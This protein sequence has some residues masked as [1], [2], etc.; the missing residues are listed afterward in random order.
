M[1]GSSQPA[2]AAAAGKDLHQRLA[3]RLGWLADLE[4]LELQDMLLGSQQLQGQQHVGQSARI[5]LDSI[6]MEGLGQGSQ[7]SVASGGTWNGSGLPL[8][9]ADEH[10]LQSVAAHAAPPALLLGSD[11]RNSNLG[12]SRLQLL[13]GMRGLQT[14]VAAAASPASATM[15]GRSSGTWWDV[16]GNGCCPDVLADGAAAGPSK[17]G[18]LL[19]P[20]DMTMDQLRQ[21]AAIVTDYE[22]SRQAELDQVAAQLTAEQAAGAAARHACFVARERDKVAAEQEQQQLQHAAALRRRQRRQD[23]LLQQQEELA[24]AAARRVRSKQAELDQELALLHQS[25][26]ADKAAALRQLKAELSKAAGLELDGPVQPAKLLRSTEQQE[27]QQKQQLDS[28]DA[29]VEPAASSVAEASSKTDDTP[30]YLGLADSSMQMTAGLSGGGS[31]AAQLHEPGSDLEV[32][33]AATTG[34]VL[35]ATAATTIAASMGLQPV[36]EVIVATTTGAS[37]GATTSSDGGAFEVDEAQEVDESATTTPRLSAEDAL[38]EVLGS[39]SSGPMAAAAATAGAGHPC[40]GLRTQQ[41][42][43]EQHSRHLTGLHRHGQSTAGA[44]GADAAAAKGLGGGH[45]PLITTLE[46]LV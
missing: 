4:A 13:M 28:A 34:G 17:P 1:G 18:A 27:Q 36:M 37:A 25:A 40:L 45:A 30:R 9:A 41:Q 23:L 15:S 38:V 11:S 39:G 12:P 26:E 21:A 29:D 5:S 44:V 3:E 42:Q 33:V 31:Q 19:L 7:V 46:V 14:V 2:A 16:L 24:A 22:A 20:C 35:K 43:Q 8:S 6:A 10:E 32:V